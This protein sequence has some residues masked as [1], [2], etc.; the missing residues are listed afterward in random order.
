MSRFLARC[1]VLLCAAAGLTFAGAAA[2]QTVTTTVVGKIGAYVGP[3]SSPDNSDALGL[4]GAKGRNLAGK[5][6][7]FTYTFDA[8]AMVLGGAVTDTY[9]GW[10]GA[11]GSVVVK[12]G[13]RT[14]EPPVDQIGNIGNTRV[15]LYSDYQGQWALYQFA[16]SGAGGGDAALG[17][18]VISLKHAFVPGNSLTESFSY[19]P[20]PSERKG[21]LLSLDITSGG[22]R[23]YLTADVLSVSYGP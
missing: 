17:V 18:Q 13:S 23:E 19:T 9:A 20:P 8:S 3:S 1:L 5:L 6:M 21:E 15:Y 4:F 7:T 14:A 11:T 12:V 16:Q 2:A 22:V 10:S